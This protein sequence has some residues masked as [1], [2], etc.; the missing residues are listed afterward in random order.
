MGTLLIGLNHKTAPVDVREKLAFS[1]EG[2]ATALLLFHKEFPAA[3]AALWST[4][5]RVEIL[6][7][8]EDDSVGPQ[9][10]IALLAQLKGAPAAAFAPYLYKSEG[11]DAVRHVFRVISGLDSMVLGEF[12]IV[13]QLKQ[14]YQLAHEQ[15]TAGPVLHRLFHHA[16][17]VSKRTRSETTICDGKTSVPSVAVDVIARS[18]PDFAG[19]RI[20]MVGAGEM[21]QLTSDY[22]RQAEARDLVVTTRTLANGRALAQACNGQAVA[23]NQLDEQ[24]VLADVVITATACPTSILTTARVR[25]CQDLRGER[26]L[27]LVDLAVP[28]NI[29]AEAAR[30]PGVTLIDVDALGRMVDESCRRRQAAV[31]L[32]EKIIEDEIGAFERWTEESRVG[33]YIEQMY[34]DVRALADI[35][36]RSA[37][38]RCPD[39]SDKQQQAVS[40]LVDRLVGKLMHPCIATVREQSAALSAQALAA[41]FRETRIGFGTHREQPAADRSPARTGRSRLLR[42]H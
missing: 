7:H 29:D 15:Q 37:L 19:K 20:L 23:F 40:Q 39:L 18:L 11:P 22:L 24:L 5:N 12:Q 6:T 25:R 14:A 4:C 21:A 27:L 13:S 36:L 26:P 34:Q 16:F 31:S 28:R 33:P 42:T 30:V 35:E 1:R 8:S 2:A 32:C 38:A 9:Q 17:G 10:V 41:A 3:E